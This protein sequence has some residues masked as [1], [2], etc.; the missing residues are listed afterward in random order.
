MIKDKECLNGSQLELIKFMEYV[1]PG[2]TK[3]F[4]TLIMEALP[5]QVFY[6]MK[7][8]STDQSERHFWDVLIADGGESLKVKEEIDTLRFH[9]GIQSEYCH[10][11]NFSKDVMQEHN[12]YHG[13]VRRS[14]R[15]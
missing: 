10:I 11:S 1:V 12:F 8:T 4:F 3:E 15:L 13:N 7:V 14:C 2:Y 9:M 6:Q 5:K